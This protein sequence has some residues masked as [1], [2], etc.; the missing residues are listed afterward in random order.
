MNGDTASVSWLCPRSFFRANF[1]RSEYLGFNSTPEPRLLCSHG[2][3]IRGSILHGRQAR[4]G[5]V[6]LAVQLSDVAFDLH[7][8]DL[9]AALNERHVEVV[10][11]I[12]LPAN[13]LD[14]VAAGAGRFD[15]VDEFVFGA[16]DPWI[17]PQDERLKNGTP[18]RQRHAP[19]S[20]VIRWIVGRWMTKTDQ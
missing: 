11:I 13:A 15:H 6:E 16:H 5:F 4:L 7:R 9:P 10:G 19:A 3:G 1:R 20:P 17:D 8:A 18:C 2:A 14:T 12:L